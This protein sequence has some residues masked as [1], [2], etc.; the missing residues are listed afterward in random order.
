M[1][2]LVLSANTVRSSQVPGLDCVPRG[3]QPAHVRVPATRVRTPLME[4]RQGNPRAVLC[5]QEFSIPI[6]SRYSVWANDAPIVKLSIEATRKAV[7]Q[8]SVMTS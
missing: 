6:Q 1:G 7:A 4:I 3:T 8:P 5:S 2:R